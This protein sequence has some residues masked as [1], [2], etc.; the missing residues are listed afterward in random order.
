MVRL[1]CDQTKIPFIPKFRTG[2]TI[3]GLGGQIN[4]LH[5]RHLAFKSYCQW[6][7]RWVVVCGWHI[8]IVISKSYRQQC[9]QIC[10][11]SDHWSRLSQW[12]LCQRSHHCTVSVTQPKYIYNQP[13]TFSAQFETVYGTSLTRTQDGYIPYI[14][15]D[16]GLLLCKLL[17]NYSMA[18]IYWEW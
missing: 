8:C 13:N 3:L 10:Q 9:V 14:L 15:S 12:T 16:E 17:L 5:I 11:I 7:E 6:G 1:F 18:A 2:K 4:Y